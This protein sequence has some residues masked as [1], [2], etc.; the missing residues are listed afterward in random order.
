ME[1]GAELLQTGAI[2]M[3]ELPSVSQSFSRR[4]LSPSASAN[5][6][7][8]TDSTALTTRQDNDF[9][10]APPMPHSSSIGL[11]QLVSSGRSLGTDTSASNPDN[12]DNLDNLAA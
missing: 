6:F 12:L 9:P 3:T 1:R 5:V 7:A 2:S 10:D 4:S 8:G 11:G